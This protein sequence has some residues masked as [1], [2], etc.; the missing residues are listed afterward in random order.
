M[1]SMMFMKT[2]LRRV[3][4]TALVGALPARPTHAE[5]RPIDLQKS[6]VTVFVY[7]SGLLSVLADNHTLR[8]PLATGT[9]SETSPAAV[10]IAVNAVELS[11]LDP[12]LNAKDREEVR[13]RMVGP[14]V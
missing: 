14:E 7:R 8:A 4:V 2:V 12:N 13:R 6:S 3:I 10:R 1:A 5:I 11:V 9:I